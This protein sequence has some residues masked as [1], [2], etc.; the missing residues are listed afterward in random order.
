MRVDSFELYVTCQTIF[1]VYLYLK[2]KQQKQL[3]Q[4]QQQQQM[5]GYISKGDNCAIGSK[6]I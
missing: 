2:D 4:Q 1:V 5:D 6:H 3:R